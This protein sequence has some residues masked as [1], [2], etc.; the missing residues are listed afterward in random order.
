MDIDI[1]LNILG[2]DIF[3][4]FYSYF[5]LEMSIEGFFP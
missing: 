3:N 5:F 4:D 1:L 2:F